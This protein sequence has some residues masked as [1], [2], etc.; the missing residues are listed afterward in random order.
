MGVVLAYNRKK[1][2]EKNEEDKEL[3]GKISGCGV[4]L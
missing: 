1:K 4:G 3:E 2:E